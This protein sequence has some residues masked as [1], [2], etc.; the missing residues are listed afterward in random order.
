M[1]QKYIS[2]NYV[3]RKVIKDL[4]I[5]DK[6]VFIDDIIEW[7]G[8]GLQYIGSYYQY[9][10]KVA[11]IIITDY[12]GELP[13]DFY[14]LIRLHDRVDNLANSFNSN[15]ITRTDNTT[16]TTNDVTRSKYTS[17]DYNIVGNIITTSFKTG[18]LFIQYQGIP[19]DEDGFPMIPDNINYLDA[20]MWKCAYQLSI[21]GYTF[22]STQLNN[23]Q[24]VESKWNRYCIQAR[25]NM[26]MP[27]AD[28]LERLKNIMIRFKPDLNQYYNNFDT[29]GKQEFQNQRGNYRNNFR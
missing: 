7:I 15:L 23:F 27:D 8:E 11:D 12:K 6:E 25:A 29:L 21:K 13:C 5:D 26:N 4:G 24:Y 17:R 28:T 16:N 9:C 2:I 14:A 20:L 19:L 10:D 18:T 1:I 22:K 3:I